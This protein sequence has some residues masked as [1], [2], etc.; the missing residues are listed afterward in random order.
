MDRSPNAVALLHMAELESHRNRFDEAI[1]HLRQANKIFNKSSFNSSSYSSRGGSNSD[2]AGR[3]AVDMRYIALPHA[4]RRWKML[5]H[6]GGGSA[7]SSSSLKGTTFTL[8]TMDPIDQYAKRMGRAATETAANIH[9]LMGITQ[10]RSNP[11][12]PEVR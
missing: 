7:S 2:N 9:A 3:H 8:T 12:Q 1:K 10:F 11:S 6:G 5:S 4:E